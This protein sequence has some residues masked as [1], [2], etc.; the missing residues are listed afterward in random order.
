M[1]AAN[2]AVKLGPGIAQAYIVRGRLLAEQVRG[3]DN[4][5]NYAEQPENEDRFIQT[6]SDYNAAIGLRP[7]DGDSHAMR[8]AALLDLAGNVG[9]PCLG[10]SGLAKA[11]HRRAGG[12][13][14]IVREPAKFSGQAFGSMSPTNPNAAVVAAGIKLGLLYAADDD[15]NVCA[16]PRAE[17]RAPEVRS[18]GRANAA[19][20]SRHHRR[21]F[22]MKPVPPAANL[23]F[24]N[25]DDGG[26]SHADRGVQSRQREFS[27]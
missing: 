20:N 19:A 7:D 21:T 8:A 4:F 23:R 2:R 13:E 12:D 25:V 11:A 3:L 15:L 26:R 27:R 24:E 9:E 22:A 6:L 17:R 16:G 10:E 5:A 1:A 18:S 14:A